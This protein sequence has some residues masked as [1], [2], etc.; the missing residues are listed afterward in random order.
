M[1][2]TQRE[3]FSTRT[4]E[5][6]EIVITR[7]NESLDW[8]EG[9]E[10][11]CT[12]YN[13]GAPFITKAK[14]I[15][16]PNNGVGLETILRHIITRYHSLSEITMFCQGNINDR[17]DQ[18]IFPFEWYFTNFDSKGIK[19]R[20]S[21]M[22]DSST[23]RYQGRCDNE[24]CRAI[25]NRNLGEFRKQVVGIPYSK[26]YDYFVRGDWISLTKACILKKPRAYYTH[27]YNSCRWKRGIYVEECWYLER[28]LHTIFTKP[29]EYKF[30][31]PIDDTV[32]LQE[33]IDGR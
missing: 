23:F 27:L 9:A 13:K 14:C 25:G 6:T 20:E 33:I 8:I 3:F 22:C 26:A 29:Y 24:S 12:V 1:D 11:V 32:S 10:H 28:S 16:V 18:I 30:R 19:G 15:N 4:R 2:D 5:Q 17:E 21:T 7:F 31:F